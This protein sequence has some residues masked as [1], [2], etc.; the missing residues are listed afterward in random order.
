CLHRTNIR[1]ETLP[2]ANTDRNTPR[3]VRPSRCCGWAFQARVRSLDYLPTFI[4]YQ[5]CS[6]VGLPPFKASIARKEFYVCADGF[7]NLQGRTGEFGTRSIAFDQS[8]A[9]RQN[10]SERNEW[11]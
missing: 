1:V 7:Q 3:R 8:N 6:T 2:L 11:P 5:R 10:S 9:L 4:G